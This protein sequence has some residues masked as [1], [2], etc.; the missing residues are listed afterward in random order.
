MPATRASS[1]AARR[2]QRKP[3]ANAAQQITGAIRTSGKRS[4][5]AFLY[6]RQAGRTAGHE[7]CPDIRGLHAG[8]CQHLGNGAFNAENGVGNAASNIAR[9]APVSMPITSTSLIGVAKA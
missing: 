8:L 7:N 1:K 6:H 9:V 5:T 2:I 3:R 4:R